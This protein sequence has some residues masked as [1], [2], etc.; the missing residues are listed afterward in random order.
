[1]SWGFRCDPKC[2]KLTCRVRTDSG[3]VRWRCPTFPSSREI[4]RCGVS[5]DFPIVDTC[6]GQFLARALFPVSQPCPRIP[7]GQ[8]QRAVA[9]PRQ[10]VS[11]GGNVS[12]G[13]VGASTLVSTALL[14]PLV[15]PVIVLGVSTTTAATAGQQFSYR[16]WLS[17]SATA[18]VVPEGGDYLLAPETVQALY[19]VGATY[20]PLGS[21]VLWPYP[22][23][24]VKVR[25]SNLGT[26]T[27]EA[28]VI[29]YGGG[30]LFAQE[31]APFTQGGFEAVPPVGA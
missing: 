23:A 18:D 3:D 7:L 5:A 4:Q 20:F 17:Q 19:S 15:F 13:G 1:M 12:I 11:L 31:S 16:A 30:Q 22:T 14:G 9:P 24:R 2:S 26:N 21:G 27:L 29:G 6:G 8:V 10:P 25:I 28:W